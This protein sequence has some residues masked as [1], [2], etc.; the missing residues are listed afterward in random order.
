MT[1]RIWLRENDYEDVVK[2]IDEAMAKMAVR[3]SKQ[4]RNWWDILS[5]G[6][7][8]KPRIVED[9][10]FPVLRAAQIRQNKP[11]TP[12]AICRNPNEKI[13]PVNVTGRWPRRRRSRR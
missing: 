8:G 13:P 1:T 10:E 3:G 11:P 5:G 4:R 7:N 9:I 12:N 6:V 2:L